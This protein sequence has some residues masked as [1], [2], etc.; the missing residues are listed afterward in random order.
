M[1][2]Q[3]IGPN[4]PRPPFLR[5][6]QMTT[7]AI[8]LSTA[9]ALFP[10]TAV[11]AQD[12]EDQVIDLE[13]IYVHGASVL[14]EM[15]EIVA[16][17]TATGTKTPAEIID[18]PAQV[19]VVTHA[20]METR[21]PADLMQALSYTSSV[22]VDEY[23]SDNR[24]DNYR[25]RG[26]YQTGSGTYRDS[27]PLRTFNFT[28]GKIE[29][30][31]VQRIEVLKGST[32]TLFGMNGPGGLVN[33]ITKRPEPLAFGETY[34]TLG[35]RHAEIGVDFGAPLDAD[36]V[37]TY[38]ITGKL[39]EASMGSQYE[40]DDRVYLGA[41]LSWKP[42]DATS[43]TLLANYYDSDGNTGNAVPVGSTADHNTFF[44]EPDF[45]AMDRLEK[46]F[47][48]EFS[49]DFGNGLTFRQ[50]VRQS[51][52]EMIYEQ[53]YLDGT[54]PTGRYAYLMNGEIDRLAI[55][56]Q[57]QFDTSFGNVESR[58][59]FGI[60]YTRDD[61]KEVTFYGT[62]GA[63]DPNNPVYCGLGCISVAP[64]T[65]TAMVQKSTG[66]YLQEELTFNDRWILTLGGRHDKV[67][68]D[69]EGG[70]GS[71][72][73]SAYTK[74]VGLT[75]KASPDLSL[76]ANYS[77]SFDPL[78]SGY[79]PYLAGPAKPQEGTQ[80][81]IGAK[82]RPE[83]TD[84]LL[85]FALFDLSQTNVPRY[86]GVAYSQIGQID[87]RGAE[88]EGR[89]ALGDQTTLNFAYSYWDAEIVGGATGG[90]TPLLTPEH[91]ASVWA[92]YTFAP[93]GMLAG[94][95]IGGGAR[96]LGSRYADDANTTRIGSA[97]VFDAMAS[98]PLTEQTELAVNLS[99]LFDREYVSTLNFDQTAVLWGD[100]RTI[101]A[102]LRHRW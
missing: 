7:T 99:N 14:G 51:N 76:Y 61:L 43:L 65:D 26:F 45:A 35:E 1:A 28:G 92:D 30:Y 74:R 50:N 41:A 98:Y 38:R 95:K 32:S 69:V 94:L 44:G 85:S 46:S 53:A 39:Q 100:G 47:G 93:G 87:V 81:E 101:K 42:T 55:D 33:V 66:I 67:D 59:L 62:A 90:N 12:A 96:L 80:Y 5:H 9:A 79:V 20:E 91:Q 31:S 2:S 56:N 40:N 22:S 64:Y 24:Y 58:T 11:I 36:G 19:S 77:E 10:A 78:G 4:R 82:Y 68:T 6:C 34:T 49:H 3:F 23:A 27:L 83:G 63:I 21:A 71:N 70:V 60:D 73:Q 97:V 86:E 15:G 52:I 13:A 57:L 84:A 102:T 29:P 37:W 25:I 48:Y 72:S 54:S 88:F 17:Y 89:M 16:G 8:L 75:F 18:I